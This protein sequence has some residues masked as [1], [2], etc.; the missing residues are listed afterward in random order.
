MF[1]MFGESNNTVICP[2]TF[3][4]GRTPFLASFDLSNESPDCSFLADQ[5][6][7]R[8][9][10]EALLNRLI[11]PIEAIRVAVQMTLFTGRDS[12]IGVYGCFAT[13]DGICSIKSRL[14]TSRCDC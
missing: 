5:P 2:N 13:A 14:A 7:Y 6:R 8:L 1:R 3:R 10:F 4:V 12:I 11:L 9:N